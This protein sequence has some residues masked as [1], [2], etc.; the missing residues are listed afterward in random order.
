MK[1]E[2]VTPEPVK[3]VVQL[4]MSVW[5]AD[6]LQSVLAHLGSDHIEELFPMTWP[7]KNEVCRDVEHALSNR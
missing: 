5:E 3:Y 2:T 1:A 6:T 7:T 4:T